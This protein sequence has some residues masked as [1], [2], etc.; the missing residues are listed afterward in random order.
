MAPQLSELPDSVVHLL[1]ICLV[2]AA[3]DCEAASKHFRAHF[4]GHA[5]AEEFTASAIRS[6]ARE[7]AHDGS[8]QFLHA[9]FTSENGALKTGFPIRP[10]GPKHCTPHFAPAPRAKRCSGESDPCTETVQWMTMLTESV[11]VRVMEHLGRSGS[12]R[13]MYANHSL[14]AAGRAVKSFWLQVVLVEEGVAGEPRSSLTARFAARLADFTATQADR[15]TGLALRNTAVAACLK[16][17]GDILL[18]SADLQ[19]CLLQRSFGVLQRLILHSFALQEVC[20]IASHG[21]L[22][23]TLHRLDLIQCTL[24]SDIF[25]ELE[26]FPA[27]NGLG[28]WGLKNTQMVLPASW[29]SGLHK[30]EELC[31]DPV[32]AAGPWPSLQGEGSQPL[33]MLRMHLRTTRPRLAIEALPASLQVLS[34][35]TSAKDIS[36]P[37]VEAFILLDAHV[38]LILTTLRFLHDLVLSGHVKLGSASMAGFAK[39]QGLLRLSLAGSDGLDSP[40]SFHIFSSHAWDGLECFEAPGSQHFKAETVK[41]I[42]PSGCSCIIPA[43]FNTDPLETSAL[44]SLVPRPGHFLTTRSPNESMESA[45]KASEDSRAWW[46]EIVENVKRPTNSSTEFHGLVRRQKPNSPLGQLAHVSNFLHNHG[47]FGEV[48]RGPQM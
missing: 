29:P 42:L 36:N 21:R 4:H 40:E 47:D 32:E 13:A 46:A 43:P 48:C 31:L 45:V 28:I 15:V 7:M 20:A 11:L 3:Y 37:F 33:R 2:D 8:L 30:I 41:S 18:R 16:Q 9:A 34:L 23:S 25:H 1:V 38:D 10:L 39:Y 35:T 6:I 22:F 14:Y 5:A 27:L 44:Q 26:A 24:S 17:A 19:R 12:I